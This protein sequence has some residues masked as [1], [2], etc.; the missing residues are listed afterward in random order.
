MPVGPGFLSGYVIHS[1]CAFVLQQG[2]HRESRKKRKA[3]ELA[4]FYQ[5]Q[6]RESQREAIAELRK[7]F[8]KD[9]ERVAELRARR[10]FKPF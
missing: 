4:N 6:Q 8:N 5:F 3:K 7:K 10:R 9:K 2:A 1:K